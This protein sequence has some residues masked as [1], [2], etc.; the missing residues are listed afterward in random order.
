MFYPFYYLWHFLFVCKYFR[1]YHNLL[2]LPLK[3][4]STNLCISLFQPRISRRPPPSSRKT[5]SAQR[6]TSSRPRTASCRRTPRS[7]AASV[8]AAPPRGSGPEDRRPSSIWITGRHPPTSWGGTPRSRRRK[9]APGP[10]EKESPLGFAIII[11]R[12]STT[13]FW[14]RKWKIFGFTFHSVGP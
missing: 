9:S 8:A 11:S 14:E 3:N 12:W 2:L 10:A 6:T 13:R 5:P 4:D 7:A 1:V